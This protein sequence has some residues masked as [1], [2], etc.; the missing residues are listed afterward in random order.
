MLEYE[1]QMDHLLKNSALF[2]SSP[3]RPLPT[4]GPEELEVGGILGMGGF[5]VVREVNRINLDPNL[6]HLEPA[7][8][9]ETESR[10]F[11]SKN[12]LRDGHAR[13]AIKRLKSKFEDNKHRTRGMMDLAIEAEYLSHLNHPNIIKMRGSLNCSNR[14]STEGFYLVLDR[15]YETLQEKID[16]LWP[17]EYKGLSGL[18]GLPK[19][20]VKLVRLFQERLVISYD[21]ANVFRYLH[22]K[23]IVYR[24]IK[25]EN[26]GFDIRGDVKLFDFGLVKEMPPSKSNDKMFKMTPRTGS[27]PYMAPECMLV[28]PYNH[29][30][31]VF[32][33][34]M[35]LW[36]IFSLKIPCKGF[37]RFDFQEKVCK[38]KYR[39]DLSIKCPAVTK[40]VIS[41]CWHDDPLKRPE[42]DRIATVLRGELN[43]MGQEQESIRNRTTHMLNRSMNSLRR[44]KDL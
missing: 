29:K 13:Y 35:L 19:D 10:E 28:K 3:S 43:D 23:R 33:F 20:K 22:S 4:F 34:G 39:P 32:G 18:F 5:C 12:T 26:I 30:A 15:L 24:D 31:D 17:K 8:H 37:N 14:V 42:F 6:N 7:E 44:M 2:H 36:E 25:P 41:E 40:S 1:A 11:M 27:I 38:H 16:T 9:S 21:L